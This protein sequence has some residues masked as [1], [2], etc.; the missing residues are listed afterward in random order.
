MN[1]Y[2]DLVVFRNGRCD[3]PHLEH[4]R[5]AV[6]VADERLHRAPFLF[7]ANAHYTTCL[8][9]RRVKGRR[10]RSR[11]L[12]LAGGPPILRVALERSSAPRHQP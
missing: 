1:S 6:S 9:T 5:W 2:Q 12:Q 10:P 3:L 11:F 4:V 8:M 7:V